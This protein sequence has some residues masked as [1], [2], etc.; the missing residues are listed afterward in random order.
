MCLNWK[1]SQGTE[2]VKEKQD[3][4]KR[5]EKRARVDVKTNVQSQD[6][7]S[8]SLRKVIRTNI[9][10]TISSLLSEM[11][12]NGIKAEKKNNSK[13]NGEIFLDKVFSLY[14]RSA[15]VKVLIRY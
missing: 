9:L 6:T 3:K 10:I 13:N 1:A 7:K 5:W 8:V 12:L 4:K 2:R 15:N 11:L 14:Q